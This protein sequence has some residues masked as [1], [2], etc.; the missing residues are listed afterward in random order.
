MPREQL[1]AYNAV[2][3]FE[4][5]ARAREAMLAL[6]G[7]GIDGD[8]ISLLGRAAEEVASNPDPRERDARSTAEV[9]K[10]G[11][12]G[13]TAG[14][15]VGA[16]AGFV[17][18]ALA[19]GIPG[20]GPVVGSAIWA[21]T[22]GSAG[23]GAAIGGLVAGTAVIGQS[24]GWAESYQETIRSGRVLVGVHTDTREHLEKAEK[25]LTEHGALNI[26]RLDAGGKRL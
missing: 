4:D 26:E 18:G 2:A 21:A 15:G 3:T 5:M 22:L 24:E 6:E 25:I 10:A 20:I 9:A 12:L 13:A 17:G 14:A 1:A 19:F 7:G 23:T 8:D 16:V 11:A